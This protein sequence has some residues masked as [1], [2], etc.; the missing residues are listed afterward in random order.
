MG[1]PSDVGAA[2]G[3]RGKAGPR[4]CS[5]SRLVRWPKSSRSSTPIFGL[6]SISARTI[7]IAFCTGV[8]DT[9]EPEGAG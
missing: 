5:R 1:G 8:S 4:A 2:G 3:R 6:A 9:C 7:E